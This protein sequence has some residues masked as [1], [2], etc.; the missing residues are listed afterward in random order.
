ML[1]R[2]VVSLVVLLGFIQ[3]AATQQDTAPKPYSDK[4]AYDVYNVLLATEAHG[5]ST[6][7]IQQETV[8]ELGLC[9]A[10]EVTQRFNDAIA[11]YYRINAKK[12]LLQRNFASAAYEILDSKTL[13]MLLQNDQESFYKR[14]PSGHY[15]MMSAVGFS[16]DRQRAIVY[17]G[18]ACGIVC[19]KWSLRLLEKS[20]EKWHEVPGVTCET[21]SL[22]GSPSAGPI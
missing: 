5:E 19:G 17:F 12:W 10:P 20:D 9:I 6:I 3:V 2:C 11:D 21:V 7:A 14:F 15:V 8:P 18:S 1:T 22:C 13:Q 4:D 16:K